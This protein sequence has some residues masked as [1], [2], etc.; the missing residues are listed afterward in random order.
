[1]SVI[2]TQSNE[3]KDWMHANEVH[4]AFLIENETGFILPSSVSLGE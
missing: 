4:P 3:E 1:V 2:G